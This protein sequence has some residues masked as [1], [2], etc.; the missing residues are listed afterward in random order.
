MKALATAGGEVAGM[1]DNQYLLR[2]K[3]RCDVG[4]ASV[5]TLAGTGPNGSSQFSLLNSIGHQRLAAMARIDVVSASAISYFFY[6]A[7]REAA[8]KVDG[9]SE[10][11]ATARKMHKGSLWRAL[12]HTLRLGWRKQ[13]Y[14]SN[15]LLPC[16][17]STLFKRE[18]LERKLGEFTH[19]LVFYCWDYNAN[20][21]RKLTPKT[22]PEMTVLDVCRACVSIPFMHGAFHYRNMVL[23]DPIFTPHFRDIRRSLYCPND[24]HLYVSINREGEYRGVLY[25]KN[26]RHLCPVLAVM[27]DFV[28][29]CVGI[30]NFNIRSTHKNNLALIRAMQVVAD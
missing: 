16:A 4:Q 3:E 13:A 9:Y 12:S 27:W 2:F 1:S 20:R 23:V 5:L 8:I 29:L 6:M 22:H 18:F 24:N 28:S 21:L 7:A 26:S 14:F 25:L 10:Y 17:F 11:E 19:N 15:E 30:P